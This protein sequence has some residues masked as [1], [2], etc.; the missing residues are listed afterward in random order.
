MLRSS[1]KCVCPVDDFT[2]PPRA[3]GLR[4]RINIWR[5]SFGPRRVEVKVGQVICV[6]EPKVVGRDE[7]D[8]QLTEDLEAESVLVIE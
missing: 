7:V 5:M 8:S 6:L 3:H 1:S 4:E 2:R